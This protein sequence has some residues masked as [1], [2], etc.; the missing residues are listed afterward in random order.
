MGVLPKIKEKFYKTK[1]PVSGK[2]V[3]FRPFT[4]GEQKNLMLAK[5]QTEKEDDMI[6]PILAMLQNCVSNVK[7]EDLC[8]ADFE[9]LFYDV[10]SASD[11]DTLSMKMKCNKCNT[12]N[13][14]EI[15]TRND[16]EAI[17]KENKEFSI[18]IVEAEIPTKAVFKIPTMRD[19]LKMEKKQYESQE[20]KAFDLV[21]SCLSKIIQPEKVMTTNDFKHKDA[22]EFIESLPGSYLSKIESFL[23]KIP[24]VVF[25]KD[26]KC[27][28]ENCDNVL[29]AKGAITKDFLS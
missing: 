7:L 14:Y 8:T 26:I 10:R 16:F 24:T 29:I 15:N 4:V 5:G 9:K 21:A 1:L 27:C 28:G 6:V 19:S 3:D 20:E 25:N 13:E 23:K 18:D 12:E 11:G 2:D 17:N 22:L